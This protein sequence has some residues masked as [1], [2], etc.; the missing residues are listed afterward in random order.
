MRAHDEKARF[1]LVALLGL[2]LH[3]SFCEEPGRTPRRIA[4]ARDSM[5]WTAKATR[6]TPKKSYASDSCWLG[7]ADFLL[8]DADKQGKTNS[9][10]R[11]SIDAWMPRLLIRNAANP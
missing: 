10:Y 9:I 3:P 4:F 1:L 5:I 11:A 2:A 7:D 6:L 8:V